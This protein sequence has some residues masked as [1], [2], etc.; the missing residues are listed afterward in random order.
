MRLIFACLIG[1]LAQPVF[2]AKITLTEVERYLESLTAIKG[3]F[4]QINADQSRSSGIFYLS[5]PGRM[6][7]EYA[8]PFEN[9]ILI[10]AGAV[11]IY[12]SKGDST[13]QV[14]PLNRT[15][16]A[17]FLKKDIKLTGSNA[18]I[19]HTEKSG[20]TIVSTHDPKDPD[21]GQIHFV[22]A[23]NPTRL[24]QWIITNEAGENTYVVVKSLEKV[25][26]LPRSL[27]EAKTN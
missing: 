21:I 13:P 22:F 11:Y 16:L 25:K 2:A 27:F 19:A 18:V 10:W 8:A 5:R 6:R 12:D 23:P 7:F 17:Q 20:N 9:L 24:T 4:E 1:L 15:P 3:S 14:Y 26:P